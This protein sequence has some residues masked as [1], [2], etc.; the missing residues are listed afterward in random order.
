MIKLKDAEEEKLNT[1]MPTLLKTE[2][3]LVL[4]IPTLMELVTKLLL[5]VNTTKTKLFSPTKELDM[6]KLKMFKV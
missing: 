5:L 1:L 3:N 4:L 2:L 6:L